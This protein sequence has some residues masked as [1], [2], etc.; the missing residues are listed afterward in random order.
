MVKEEMVA[1]AKA[2]QKKGECEILAEEPTQ[3][4][5]IQVFED[6]IRAHDF[7]VVR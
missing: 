1:L 5:G 3:T 6:N 7:I 4:Q 2:L